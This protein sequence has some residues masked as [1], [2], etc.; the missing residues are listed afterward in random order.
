MCVLVCFVCGMAPYH[1]HCSSSVCLWGGA[2]ESELSPCAVSVPDTAPCLM[3][4]VCCASRSLL[5]A[6]W[7]R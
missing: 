6:I 4:R 2:L 1:D 5:L 7:R 3:C